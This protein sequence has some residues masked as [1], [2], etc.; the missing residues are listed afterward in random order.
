MQLPFIYCLRYQQRVLQKIWTGY[1]FTN[2]MDK[3][4]PKIKN[5]F[6]RF[7]LFLA[8][9]RH[10]VFFQSEIISVISTNRY[11]SKTQQKN[12]HFCNFNIF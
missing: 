7:R 4:E 2:F 8:G 3:V 12:I 6:C 5:K 9:S 1:T 11:F 10:F